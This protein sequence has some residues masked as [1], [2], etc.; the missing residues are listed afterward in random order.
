MK[1]V[2]R[3]VAVGLEPF[4]DKALAGAVDEMHWIS[5][6]KLGSI[7]DALK[8]SGATQA[9]MAGL[10]TP[11]CKFVK[12]LL[13]DQPV[14]AYL[15]GDGKRTVGVVWTT[16]DETPKPVQLTGAKLQLLDI[17]GRPQAART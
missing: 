12:K 8:E 4:A 9:V 3:V 17:V 11:D 7:I 13:P 1:R 14:K 6:G 15:F 10:L 2:A 5:V 16:K